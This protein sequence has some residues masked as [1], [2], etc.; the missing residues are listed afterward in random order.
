MNNKVKQTWTFARTLISLVK[1]L[2]DN[3]IKDTR[4]FWHKNY[5]SGP[6]ILSPD[7]IRPLVY[8]LLIVLHN[9]PEHSGRT[10][11]RYKTRFVDFKKSLKSGTRDAGISLHTAVWLEGLLDYFNT[12]L[13]NGNKERQRIGFSVGR[14]VIGLHLVELILKYKLD[15]LGIGYEYDHD[16][17]AL[18]GNIPAN[19]RTEA[20]QKYQEILSGFSEAWDIARSIESLLQYYGPAAITDTRYFWEPTE[21]REG[22]RSIVFSI[23]TLYPLVHALFISLHGYPEKGPPYKNTEIRFIPLEDPETGYPKENGQ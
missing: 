16:L 13:P 18:F 4:Y 22:P 6:H 5:Q 19:L 3:P 2:G 14:Q 15:E 21:H 20:E 9:Y 11:R 1:E 12:L 10:V 8:S 7:L 23:N 17:A